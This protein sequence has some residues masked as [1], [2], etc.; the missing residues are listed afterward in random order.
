M[1][2][3]SALADIND[4]FSASGPLSAL[5][6][7]STLLD[8]A[9]TIGTV[10]QNTAGILAITF[11]DKVTTAQVQAALGKIA[12]SN[13]LQSLEAA[14][15]SPITLNWVLHDGDTDAD[16]ALSSQGTTGDKSVTFPQTITLTGVNDAPVLANTALS[17]TQTED[18]AARVGAT[19]Y[20]GFQ[21]C[22]CGQYC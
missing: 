7:G 3:R 19:R 9:V 14:A 1:L 18:A 12:Y 20:G 10:R 2:S 22:W 13:P 21:A 16:R 6:E 4:I 8:G 17:I 11:A 15:T 5:S